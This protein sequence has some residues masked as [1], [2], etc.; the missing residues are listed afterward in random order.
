MVTVVAPGPPDGVEPL[1]LGPE[2]LPP[3]PEELPPPSP[4]L[5]LLLLP[6]ISKLPFTVCRQKE[7][8]NAPLKLA[9]FFPV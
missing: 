1:S 9:N 7:W 4:P 2:E 3:P 6:V 5:L 8:Q